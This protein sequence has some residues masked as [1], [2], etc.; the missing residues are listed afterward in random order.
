MTRRIPF[1]SPVSP[2]AALAG[3]AAAGYAAYVAGTW[4]RYGHP[5]P[6]PTDGGDELLD[7]FMPVYEV[8]ERH[9]TVVH[10]P[11]D[12]TFAAA[13][14]LDL[15]SLPLV[16]AI[17]KGRELILG[18]APA[19]EPRAR[20]LVADMLALGWGV[21]AETPGRAIVVGAVTK[22]WEPNPIFRTVPAE[23]F[24]TFD[25]PDYVRIAW[26]L[27][28]DPLPGGRS[29]FRTET[30]AVA[31]DAAARARFRLYWSFLSPGIWLI[32]R[33]MLAPLRRE[34]ARRA[35]TTQPAT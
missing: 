22:P 23:R 8:V 10:A 11:A 1:R 5:A 4:V 24:A 26:T 35:Q 3:V 12:V 9:G 17:F 2:L 6:A 15:T 34:A 18:A 28:A 31:T 20:G 19:A 13:R 29:R 16:R 21:L 30:R 32:R 25:E 33:A 7:R 14:D 27:R